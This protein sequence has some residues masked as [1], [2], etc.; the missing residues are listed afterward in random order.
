MIF[1]WFEGPKLLVTFCSGC[2][3]GEHTVSIE[4]NEKDA[5]ALKKFTVILQG[6]V[7]CL[8]CDVNDL[9]VGILFW[10]RYFLSGLFFKLEPR[11]LPWRCPLF[12]QELL[13][14][15]PFLDV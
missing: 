14:F 11:L 6:L 15:H 1:C 12:I 2:T 5:S 3:E 4:D 8:A 9:K 13:H 10:S 7:D